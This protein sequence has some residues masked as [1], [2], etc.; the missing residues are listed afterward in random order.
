MKILNN[1]VLEYFDFAEIQAMR[2]NVMYM[3]DYVEHLDRILTS[4]GEEVLE[5]AGN[6]SHKQA[7]EKA[8]AEYLKYQANS[9]SSVEEAYIETIKNIELEVK[10]KANK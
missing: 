9:L 4:N 3:K 5:N 2:R 10:S 8:E 7:M 6:I 1:F